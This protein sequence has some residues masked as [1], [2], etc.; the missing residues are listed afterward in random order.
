MKKFDIKKL[1]KDVAQ[2]IESIE[3]NVGDFDEDVLGQVALKDGWVFFE[4]YSHIATFR[5][6]TDL[7]EIVR[8]ETDEE[9]L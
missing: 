2:K 4:D 9:G 6:K 7:I 5:S 1:P 3:W 8:Y